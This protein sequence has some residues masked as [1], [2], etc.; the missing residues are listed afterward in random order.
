MKHPHN[1]L[2]RF[3]I[4]LE[5]NS[6]YQPD[7][8]SI[9]THVIKPNKDFVISRDMSGAV[10]SYYGDLIW[11]FSPY[12]TNNAPSQSK[13]Y[14]SDLPK[15]SI[16]EVKWLLFIM[17]YMAESDRHIRLSVSTIIG[18]Y[19]AI[20]HVCKYSLNENISISKLLESENKLKKYIHRCKSTSQLKAI[21]PIISNIAYLGFNKT[22]I[23]AIGGLT[24]EE[25]NKK[26]IFLRDEKQHPVIPPR[27]FSY[28]I[29]YLQN[30]VS[31]ILKYKNELYT[32]LEIF[33]THAKKKP[34]SDPYEHIKN[35]PSYKTISKDL[36]LCS[37][38]KKYNI[39]QV[40]NISR[41]LAR[42]QHACKT[43]IHI[44][45]GMRSAEAFSLKINCYSY[46]VSQDQK[47]PRLLGET[48]KLVGQRKTAAWVTSIEIEGA[49]SLAQW[50]ATTIAKLNSFPIETT[51]LFISTSYLF[52]PNTLPKDKLQVS[53]LAN[54][55]QEITNY[56]DTTDLIIDDNDISFLEKVDP[57]RSWQDEPL[58]QQG[59]V[60]RFTTHQFRRSL[61]FYAAQSSLVSLPSLKRQLKHITLE[62]TIYYANGSG[63]T[64]LFNGDDHFSSFYINSKP[65]A[66]ALT[67]LYEIILSNEPLY[68]A[69]GT[70]IERNIK[71]LP[72]KANILKDRNS[73]IKKFKNGEIAY[74]D[75]PLG[76]CTSIEPCNKKVM[77]EITAC[78]D[79]KRT[80][81]K[82]SKLKLV[83]DRQRQLVDEIKEIDS[84][85]LEYRM[86][87][88]ELDI[89][90]R[91][92]K[93]ILIK[94][95]TNEKH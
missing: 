26:R 61:A 11:D 20:K 37:L 47:S 19:K 62:M 54:K 79:C 3:S 89:L 76:A 43:L 27:I 49:I 87:K 92:S 53:T 55:K 4:G 39:T 12:K 80:V 90:I 85:C 35:Y 41:L 17:L 52:T 38:F 56:I 40:R 5:N 15:K 8:F 25:I 74:K 42:T 23:K 66:D 13:L 95:Y 91:F 2:P 59:N 36:G 32:L 34:H 10:L 46:N 67:Y 18:Y 29:T 88:S 68:G 83:I 81:I 75:T 57:L 94:E 16:P 14:F 84:S 50:I 44:Y 69:H 70:F 22:G 72:N 82:P 48:S 60:W 21:C 77:R 45:S 24:L 6:S 71:N 51:P 78:I 30:H 28:Y 93:K 65:E 1:Y 58:F 64:D 86:E 33:H 9:K 63:Y 31:E 73:L 7:Q